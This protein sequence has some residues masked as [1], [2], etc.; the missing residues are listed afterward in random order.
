[1]R[2]CQF[3]RVFLGNRCKRNP[4]ARGFIN[5]PEFRER[6]QCF[7]AVCNSSSCHIRSGTSVRVPA[8]IAAAPTFSHRLVAIIDKSSISCSSQ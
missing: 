7:V 6:C 8:P 5:S 4:R 1:M 2:F 3:S